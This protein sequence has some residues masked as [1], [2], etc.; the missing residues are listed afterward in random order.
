MLLQITDKLNEEK[1]YLRTYKLH[2][3]IELKFKSRQN[4]A[5]AKNSST[6]FRRHMNS[7]LQWRLVIFC[8]KAQN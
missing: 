1:Y 4:V 5:L 7:T 3:F 6:A 2:L 8:E